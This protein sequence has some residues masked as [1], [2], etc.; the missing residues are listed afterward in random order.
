[1]TDGTTAV[2]LP[3]PDDALDHQEAPAALTSPTLMPEQTEAAPAAEKKP[4]DSSVIDLV[5]QTVTRGGVVYKLSD[6]P[7]S[8]VFHMALIGLRD[9]LRNGA[10]FEKLKAGETG[11]VRSAE[12]KGRPLTAWQKAV[13]KVTVDVAKKAGDPVTV[14]EAEKLVR[15]MPKE[16][17]LV[18]KRDARVLKHYNAL[19]GTGAPEAAVS[20]VDELLAKRAK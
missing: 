1:M 14:E 10:D 9:V 7:A 6:L 5:A 20:P 13:A 8:A 16:H 3:L 18:M 15:L 12:P 2:D 4:R 11:K 19:V 17:L